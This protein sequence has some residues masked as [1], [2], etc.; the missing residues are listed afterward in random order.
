MHTCEKW[1]RFAKTVWADCGLW[2][3]AANRIVVGLLQAVIEGSIAQMFYF[4]KSRL[5]QDAVQFWD[6]Y[7]G[8]EI[9]G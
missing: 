1:V 8:L 4:V 3:L 9:P 2:A 7:Q 6:E 5:Q